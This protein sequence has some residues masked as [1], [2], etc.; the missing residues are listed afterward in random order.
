M[1]RGID[2]SAV[3]GL[4]NIDALDAAGCK[5]LIA[6]CKQGNDGKDPFFERNIAAA[7]S[8]GWAVGA[9]HFMYPLPHLDPEEQADGFYAASSLGS[10]YGDLPPAL[11][12]EWPDPDG[13]AKWNCTANQISE[14][15]RRC[16]ERVTQLYGRRPLIY[17]YPYFAQ[18][19]AAA[20]MAWLADYP[21]WIASYMPKPSI[22]KPWTD[23]TI[24]QYDGNGGAKM[25]GGGDADFNWFNGDAA[26]LAAFCGSPASTEP[27]TLPDL[28]V[29]AEYDAAPAVYSDSFAGLPTTWPG[30]PKDAA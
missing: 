25:P 16:A 30:P 22:P 1:I 3:Q 5:F 28:E 15:A 24:W 10:A 8:K 21:L 7:M 9:Y 19:L 11:D 17:I 23:W 12:L 6:K 26:A 29:T 13:W 4:L 2:A 18:R 14:F 27:P 20:S